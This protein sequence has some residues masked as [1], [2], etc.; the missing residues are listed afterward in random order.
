MSIFKDQAT[1]MQACGQTTSV[2]NLE[3]AKLYVTLVKEEYEELLEA[4]GAEH[5]LK[6]LMDC[7]VVLVGLGLSMGWDL[8]GAWNEVLRSN[9][10][11][12]D[13]STGMVTRREDGKILKGENY[14]KADVSK[15]I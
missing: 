13:Q 10:S 6:E 5:Q 1:F 15:F 14:I 9:L 7:L 3:Q 2:N 11:K 4:E 12:V 8:D